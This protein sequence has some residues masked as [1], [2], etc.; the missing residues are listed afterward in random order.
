MEQAEQV[1]NSLFEASAAGAE[2]SEETVDYLIRTAGKEERENFSSLSEDVVC[3][4]M[5]GKPIRPNA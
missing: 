1:L 2:I 4:T 3:Y 5:R